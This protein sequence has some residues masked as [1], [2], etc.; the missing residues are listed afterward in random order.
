MGELAGDGRL[1]T[2]NWLRRLGTAGVEGLH[3][4][5]AAMADPKDQILACQASIKLLKAEISTMGPK[6]DDPSEMSDLAISARNPTSGVESCASWAVKMKEWRILRGHFGKI[7]ALQFAADSK[8]LVSAAQDGKLYWWNAQTTNKVHSIALRSSWVMTCASS[9]DG[10]LLAC[11]GLDNIC[12]L[13][14]LP[15]PGS[16]DAISKKTYTELA[17]H[18]GYLSCCRFID[19][20]TLVT[21][22]GMTP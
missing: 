3:F 1:T 4:Q 18:E 14:K 10:Q 21:S 9:P 17:Q 19:D 16:N 12:S 13:F 2:Q 22:S 6:T 8:H 11:G 20:R 5:R 7:Y 15:E